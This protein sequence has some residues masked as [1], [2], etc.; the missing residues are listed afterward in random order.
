M[1]S[2]WMTMA[3]MA[4]W[5]ATGASAKIPNNGERVV[6]YM[7]SGSFPGTG[8]ELSVA[9]IQAKDLFE[10]AGVRLEWRSGSPKPDPTAARVVGIEFV[11]S[12]PSFFCTPGHEHSLAAARPYAEGPA[13]IMVFTDRVLDLLWSMDGHSA[14]KVLGHIL[15]HE[16]THVLEGISRHSTTGL[17]K[18]LWSAKD[19]TNLTRGGLQ[20]AAEDVEL[21]HLGIMAAKS[22]KLTVAAV[23][24]GN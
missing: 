10:A 16:L 23:P 2:F 22:A 17:M 8:S 1:K 3:A 18:A 11:A 24:T 6:V 4:A 7:N 15:A 14:G 9:R 12:A 20:F 19:Y 13:A 21:L 5:G